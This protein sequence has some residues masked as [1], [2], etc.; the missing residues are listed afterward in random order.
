MSGGIQ[1]SKPIT[2]E[3]SQNI[4]DAAKHFEGKTLSSKDTQST[5]TA[6]AAG[7]EAFAQSQN[8]VTQFGTALQEDAGH[9]HDLGARF[10]EFDQMMAEFNK[11]Q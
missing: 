3:E 11:N 1:I 2:D 5:I 7:Q 6:N 10:E 8:V 4:D 9:I